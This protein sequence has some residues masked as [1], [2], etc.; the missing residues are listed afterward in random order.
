[1]KQSGCAALDIGMESGDATILR[2]M[3]KNYTPNHIIKSINTAK[4]LDIITHCNLVIGFP[5][6]ST[7]TITNTINTLEK[8]QPDTYDAYLLDIAPHT[9]ICSHTEMFGIHGNRLMWSHR[10]MDTKQPYS[11]N[12]M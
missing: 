8:A 10:T 6:E 11:E 1:M 5:G 4:E 2:K 3:G 9:K 12:S 7:D